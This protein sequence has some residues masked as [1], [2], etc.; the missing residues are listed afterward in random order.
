MSK[1]TEN[2]DS[3]KLVYTL[4]EDKLLIDFKSFANPALIPYFESESFQG[5]SFSVYRNLQSILFSV[6]SFKNYLQREQDPNSIVKSFYVIDAFSRIHNL[7]MKDVCV[8]DA[9]VS[10]CQKFATLFEDLKTS[11]T[12]TDESQICDSE[13]KRL[14]F[15]TIR[16]GELFPRVLTIGQDKIIRSDFKHIVDDVEDLIKNGVQLGRSYSRLSFNGGDSAKITYCPIK[17]V[18]TVGC[19]TIPLATYYHIKKVFCI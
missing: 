13:L 18:F 3:E 7:T 11:Q 6:D 9:F 17:K 15:G 2:W 19:Q 14:Q 16:S 8:L 1:N 12:D 5:K 10:S 4:D